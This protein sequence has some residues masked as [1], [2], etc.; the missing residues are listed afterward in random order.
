M[1]E[2][3]KHSATQTE[4]EQSILSQVPEDKMKLFVQMLEEMML[5]KRSLTGEAG[6]VL[7]SRES[8]GR[9]ASTSVQMR[10]LIILI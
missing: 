4:T 5:K 8:A 10:A 2:L 1:D 3:K 7:Y 6:D 9:W